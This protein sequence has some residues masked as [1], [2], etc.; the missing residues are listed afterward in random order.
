MSHPHHRIIRRVTGWMMRHPENLADGERQQFAAVLAHCPELGLSDPCGMLTSMNEDAFWQLIED[1]RPME[2]DPDADLLADTLT[3]RL[4]QSPLS[5]TIG[6]AEQLSWA[7]YRLDRK[8]Y[9]HDLGGDAFLYARAAVVAAGRTEFDSVLEDSA[10]FAP[11]A[12]DLIWAES[13]LYTPDRA[14]RRITGEEW[15]RDTRYSYE[16]YSNTEGWAD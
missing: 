16:S 2:P 14:Y 15:D 4:A 12:T 1:C 10:A 11:Y 8:E 3:E 7:L 13:L 6:F 5:L 9:G